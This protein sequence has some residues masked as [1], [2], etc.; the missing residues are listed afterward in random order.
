MSATAVK[1]ATMSRAQAIAF[2]GLSI[3]LM[4]VGA[5]I[6]VPIGPVPFTL[7]V[8]VIAFVLFVLPGWLPVAAI[9]GYL[10][11]GAV[12]V[13]VFSG[14]RGGIGVLMG[15]TGGFLLGYLVAGIACVGLA[16]L[17]RGAH[18]AEISNTREVISDIA[19]GLLFLAIIY[20][21]GWAQ[22]MMVANVDAVQSFAVTVAPF[23]LV[24]AL[25]IVAAII[26]AQIIHRSVGTLSR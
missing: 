1:K 9:A 12:G 10:L 18:P 7:Q 22:Y 3:A 16:R 23:I 26:V 19:V 15:P 11:L 6:T 20:V 14:M 13:P 25:K 4:A 5:W 2:V 21:C 24:D 8:F 17:T